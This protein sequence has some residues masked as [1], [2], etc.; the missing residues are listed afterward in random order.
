MEEAAAEDGA[1]AQTQQ[2]A[3]EKTSQ[4]AAA[5]LERFAHTPGQT[6]KKGGQAGGSTTS[7]SPDWPHGGKKESGPSSR[8]I[9][10]AGERSNF[11]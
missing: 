9:R 3:K 11:K 7:M 10:S 2:G 1:G 8:D 4:A 5:K 6:P